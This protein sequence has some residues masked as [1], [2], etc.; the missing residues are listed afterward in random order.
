M[1]D[2]LITVIVPC[3]NVEK[4]VAKCLDS[5]INQTYKNLE[6]IIVEDVSND[7]TLKIVEE[8]TKKDSRIKL[9]R[10]EKN[11]GLAYSRNVGLANSNGNYISFIDSDDYI[12][13]DFYEKMINSIK[14]NHS[15][16]AICDFQVVNEIDNT[17]EIV[18]CCVEK[19][20]N[21]LNVIN[22]GFAA[23]ACNKIFKKELI[24]KYKFAEGKVN[25]DIAVVIP[26]VVEANK[27]SYASDIYYYYIQRTGSIQNSKFS[28]K[29]FDIFYGVDT[30]LDR[31]KNCDNYN[32]IKDAIIF[33][34]III[35]LLYVITKEKDKKARKNILKKY[36]MLSKKYNITK[37]IFFKKFIESCGKKH[38]IYYKKLVEFTSNNHIFLA[39]NLISMYDALYK[40]LKKSVIPNIDINR[41]VEA[42]HKQS[43][44]EDNKIKVSVI[45]PNYN[46][47][48]FLYERVYSILSQDYK[49]YELI[50]LD[51]KSTDNS[52][53]VIEEI[54]DKIKDYVN[55]K[56]IYNEENSGSAFKQWKKGF[57]EATGDYIWIAEADD[58]CESN[59]ISNLVKPI[60]NNDKIMISY[61]DTA[62][63]DYKGNIM[64]KSIKPEIDIQK[65]KHWNKS[66]TNNGIDEINNYSYLNNTIANVSSCIIKKGNYEDLFTRAGNYKQAGDWLIYTDIMA[67]GDISYVDKTLNYYRLHGNN[68]SSTMNHKKHLSELEMLYK[69]YTEKYGLN[70]KQKN[71]IGERIKF[72][73]DTWNIK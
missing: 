38:A 24:T 10:N 46:Y 72:L 55:V 30:T 64:M 44:L 4:Y 58:F 43:K 45:I 39:N 63:I 21:K 57:G 27:I 25:E 7:N 41:V 13:L 40:I 60:I 20:F 15:D 65:S 50:I 69:Y 9:I 61:C 71:K 11:G 23:S 70:D 5:I 42:A 56:A 17:K 18:K 6:I 33:N 54:I 22:N 14:N 1:K 16:I 66:Y 53:T 48:K 68:V 35:L 2:E 3:Y 37:N 67:L 19:E 49:I 47:A 52:E 12:S 34:Q 28:E 62:F 32:E 59:L 51:D 73:K 29:R 8:Y 31:I 36:R 26:L